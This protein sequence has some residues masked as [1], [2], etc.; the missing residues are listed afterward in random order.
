[1]RIPVPKLP[2]I[3]PEEAQSLKV[4]ILTNHVHQEREAEIFTSLEASLAPVGGVWISH[5]KRLFSAAR[6]RKGGQLK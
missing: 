2:V 3:T 5:G 1:M 4:L 6:H